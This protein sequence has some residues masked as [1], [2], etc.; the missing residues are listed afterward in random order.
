MGNQLRIVN[1]EDAA[2]VLL[3]AQRVLVIG[4]SG[5]GKSTLSR[6]LSQRFSWD[7]LSIDR[8]VLWL[9]GW[10]QRS[11]EEQLSRIAQLIE[12]DRW[13]M[14]GTNPSTFDRRVP[15]SDI[16]I[17]VRMPRHLNI[18]G[19]LGRWGKY[20]GRTRPE[21]APGCPERVTWEF[22]RFVWTWERAFA[23]LVIEALERSA[24]DKPILILTS[25][26]QM[27]RLLSLVGA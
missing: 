21:M 23:P 8:D 2:E 13:V 12:G 10:R 26:G 3:G 18:W 19:I 25:R 11:K 20:L 7:Y 16:V 4:C 9:A 24:G 17:W 15:R 27:R 22:F 5:G 14:D 1:V 6:K